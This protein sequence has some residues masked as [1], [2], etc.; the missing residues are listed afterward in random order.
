MS[1]IENGPSGAGDAA[2]KAEQAKTSEKVA[3]QLAL[4][5]LGYS[6]L[7]KYLAA[8]PTAV[9]TSTIDIPVG[10]NIIKMPVGQLV[11]ILIG[12]ADDI[13]AN[14]NDPES[15]DSLSA[16]GS[17]HRLK[18]VKVDLRKRH[19][20]IQQAQPAA[21][22]EAAAAATP[23]PET[24]KPNEDEV[25]PETAREALTRMQSLIA[26]ARRHML[27]A[28][29]PGDRIVP[30]A[31]YSL[32][33]LR[34]QEP[35][36]TLLGNY[37]IEIDSIAAA[38]K[39][40]G[41]DTTLTPE[42]TALNAELEDLIIL[43][44]LRINLE[45]VRSDLR[46]SDHAN[47]IEA[48][49]EVCLQE[50][51]E[52]SPFYE[53]ASDMAAEYLADVGDPDFVENKLLAEVLEVETAARAAFDS[54]FSDED[55][56][57]S[58]EQTLHETTFEQIQQLE[59]NADLMAPSTR[60]VLTET[61]LRI[62]LLYKIAKLGH[63]IRL[64]LRKPSPD[65]VAITNAINALLTSL[66][67][68]GAQPDTELVAYLE[69]LLAKYD[70]VD[71]R[72]KAKAE[73]K[74]AQVK[75]YN[76]ILRAHL[77]SPG[78]SK[79][80]TLQV[81]SKE[82]NLTDFSKS[83]KAL[84][85][86]LQANGYVDQ[87]AVAAASDEFSAISAAIEPL[88]SAQILLAI[89]LTATCTNLKEYSELIHSDLYSSFIDESEHLVDPEIKRHVAAR[90]TAVREKFKEKSKELHTQV[91][92]ALIKHVADSLAADHTWNPAEHITYYLSDQLG[93]EYHQGFSA[94]QLIR[95]FTRE[96]LTSV[97]DRDVTAIM[98]KV[99]ER[100]L[101]LMPGRY[102][103]TTQE[104]YSLLR[105]P[106]PTAPDPATDQR[107][108]GI[109]A[110][111]QGLL[112]I[113][114]KRTEEYFTTRAAAIT[115]LINR[116]RERKGKVRIEEPKP[117]ET[118]L[119][120]EYA[121]LEA[122]IKSIMD[123]DE[124]KTHFTYTGPDKITRQNLEALLATLQQAHR[125]LFEKGL[126]DPNNEAIAQN[127]TLKR[128]V[129]SLVGIDG[130]QGQYWRA[131]TILKRY[132]ENATNSEAA[133]R[134]RADQLWKIIATQFRAFSNDGSSNDVTRSVTELKELAEKYLTPGERVLLDIVISLRDGVYKAAGAEESRHLGWADSIKTARPN[135]RGY[136]T[137]LDNFKVIVGKKDATL[138]GTQDGVV[139]GKFTTKDSE[140]GAEVVIDLD[141]AS[142]LI[143]SYFAFGGIVHPANPVIYK[144][145]ETNKILH[146]SN[147]QPIIE[148]WDYG[149][150]G[151]PAKA[152]AENGYKPFVDLLVHDMPE[153][154]HAPAFIKHMF[155]LN[156]IG[157][158]TRYHHYIP[159]YAAWN[160]SPIDGFN[161]EPTS[162]AARLAELA[163][164]AQTSSIIEVSSRVFSWITRFPKEMPGIP[165]D[166]ICDP[167]QSTLASAK[168]WV[169]SIFTRKRHGQ[170]S[171]GGHGSGHGGGH[172]APAAIPARQ[173]PKYHGHF[174]YKTF[175]A[176]EVIP[177]CRKL[178]NVRK[179]AY[180]RN[181]DIA[182]TSPVD[183]PYVQLR[184]LQHQPD[185]YNWIHGQWGDCK[186]DA[187]SL[188]DFDAIQNAVNDFIN[189]VDKDFQPLK[190]EA[191]LDTVVGN[192]IDKVKL[193]K[194]IF[195]LMDKGTT[196][197]AKISENK[198]NFIRLIQL[199]CIMYLYKIYNNY[200]EHSEGFFFGQEKPT[201]DKS[202]LKQ[203]VGAVINKEHYQHPLYK[204][205]EVVATLIEAEGSHGGEGA[206][207]FPKEVV[208]YE[209]KAGQE[210]FALKDVLGALIMPRITRNPN[211]WQIFFDP[212]QEKKSY[213][214]NLANWRL[215]RDANEQ[216]DYFKWTRDPKQPEDVKH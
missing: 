55:A 13:V 166:V 128:K 206:G 144:R 176:T 213:Q 122:A 76:A 19:K 22:A 105:E 5:D 104:G 24:G 73:K 65:K 158:E 137:E 72:E 120:N 197:P 180:M 33:A 133:A 39:V 211:P 112:V 97:R 138:P 94:V 70:P 151:N 61:A 3:Q 159:G 90:V 60:A 71:E 167:S 84:I 12:Y 149:A 184:D 131:E 190:T 54:L 194:G 89:D 106:L 161:A 9:L 212:S 29:Y 136:F 88:D 11:D 175:E 18:A 49:A 4:I 38:A 93:M 163:Y 37:Q 118:K 188:P 15:D 79:Y 103:A 140:T 32:D 173:S 129:L 182:V 75:Q 181:T 214:Q 66:I 196:D 145:D 42:L 207:T 121:A 51:P 17:S 205:G 40:E 101:Q 31:D 174:H 189:F 20:N 87:S 62:Q 142:K 102:F 1:N 200:T 53:K 80:L 114:Q 115:D 169:K 10:G 74:L 95:S 127:E 41:N 96:G 154:E 98:E 153:L 78:Y 69:S 132:L 99:H 56:L 155:T 111:L 125:I 2:A 134:K 64:E 100:E 27:S 58:L 46:G 52:G 110:K 85:I 63:T 185:L 107:I 57:F 152:D 7:Q 168:E 165:T 47:R 177:H 204:F 21:P 123:L 68:S 44:G 202:D 203:R 171:N 139:G 215:S 14:S 26:S 172:G 193:F 157:S 191:M 198:S 146:D 183:V 199:L 81:D 141:K 135:F 82:M 187:I 156:V 119:P 179:L 170:S 116:L 50:F 91:V 108:D 6:E 160:G 67:E 210:S 25:Q 109:I 34:D 117:K 48:F 216:R 162:I 59:Q 28:Q 35:L 178:D 126:L 43:D 23:N 8:E 77:L 124:S 130:K 148:P 92:R 150:K 16:E 195:P 192:M 208:K 186:L 209:G 45:G 83:A 30:G 86:E 113:V 143:D 201:N 147:G 164:K 36:M